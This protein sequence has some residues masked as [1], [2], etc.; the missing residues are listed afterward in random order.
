VEHSATRLPRFPLR[1]NRDL[2]FGFFR[3]HKTT[4]QQGEIMFK[5]FKRKQKDV[6]SMSYEEMVNSLWNDKAIIIATQERMSHTLSAMDQIQ[7]NIKF[8]TESVNKEFGVK[9]ALLN[10]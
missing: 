1:G 2:L 7:F 9:P 3:E 8:E 6:Y 4:K 10:W 5:I